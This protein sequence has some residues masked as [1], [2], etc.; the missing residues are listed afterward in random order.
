MKMWDTFK[1]PYL[2]LRIRKY[3][4]MDKLNKGSQCG[5]HKQGNKDSEYEKKKIQSMYVDQSSA[6]MYSDGS[7]TKVASAVVIRKPL[8]K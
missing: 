4:K 1:Y 8:W 2:F 6:V 3:K 7:D 5:S